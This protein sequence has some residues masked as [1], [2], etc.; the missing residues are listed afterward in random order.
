MG[1]FEE[2]PV[3]YPNKLSLLLAICHDSPFQY[4]II[5]SRPFLRTDHGCIN[6]FKSKL[7][8]NL[9]VS[10]IKTIASLPFAFSNLGTMSEIVN[11]Q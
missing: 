8:D 2:G 5:G 10:I 4:G 7:N 6:L 9:P 3:D 11:L 1:N